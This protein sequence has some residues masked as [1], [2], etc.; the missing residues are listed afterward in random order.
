M[1]EV[2]R[3]EQSQ[4]MERVKDNGLMI[5]FEPLDTAIPEAHSNTDILIT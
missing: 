5:P 2:D 4:K 1:N 3:V